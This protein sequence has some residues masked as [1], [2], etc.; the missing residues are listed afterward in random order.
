MATFELG[1]ALAGEEHD[2]QH[3]V[4]QAQR[5]EAAGFSFALISGHH[6]WVDRVH[7]VGPDQERFVRFYEERVLPEFAD[8]SR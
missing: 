2:P 3:R 5:A 8:G 6:P 7:Q 4:R 1:Y